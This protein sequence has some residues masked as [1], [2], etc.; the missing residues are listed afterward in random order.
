MPQVTVFLPPDLYTRVYR[1][2]VEK[3]TTSSAIMRRLAE[4]DFKK[5]RK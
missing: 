5:V 2:A 4:D 3:K 1:Q